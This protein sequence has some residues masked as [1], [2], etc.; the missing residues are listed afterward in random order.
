[1][2]REFQ[3]QYLRGV[4]GI[5]IAPPDYPSEPHAFA[6][7]AEELRTQIQKYADSYPYSSPQHWRIV[8]SSGAPVE[9]WKITAGKAK[10]LKRRY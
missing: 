9:R 10:R 8:T 5:W 7:S 6:G 4:M 1:M 3:A 2:S